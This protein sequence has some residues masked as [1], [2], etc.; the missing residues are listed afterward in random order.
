M[1]KALRIL[2]ILALIFGAVSPLFPE[3]TK[4]G[5]Y[6]FMG[7][8]PCILYDQNNNLIFNG[9]AHSLEGKEIEV[10]QAIDTGANTNII[11]LHYPDLSRMTIGPNSSFKVQ[12]AHSLWLSLGKIWV[13]I[14]HLFSQPEDFQVESPNAVAV[15]HG[16]E[17]L[18]EQSPMNG[19]S[20]IHV[21]EG[22][23]DVGDGKNLPPVPLAQGHFVSNVKKGEILKP[24]TF[25]LSQIHDSWWKWNLAKEKKFSQ[26]FQTH[27]DKIMELL[28]E[29]VNPAK[30]MFQ[31]RGIMR[32][33]GFTREN[34]RRLYRQN[35]TSFDHE[36]YGK[37]RFHFKHPQRNNLNYPSSKPWT[38]KGSSQQQTERKKGE[39]HHRSQR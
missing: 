10:G 22:T 16:T 23:V 21:F 5:Y 31:L 30:T 36:N 29:K 33:H 14:T 25:N 12:D 13:K 19:P 1:Q 35:S 2:L 38:K 9:D 28:R 24:E 15:A 39:P 7:Q 17:F 32:Q 26:F 3:E 37:G 4:T 34:F 18:V 11:L 27:H 20:A 8:G 6:V